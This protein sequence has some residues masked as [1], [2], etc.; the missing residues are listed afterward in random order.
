[1]SM[2]SA[3]SMHARE[4]PATE[5]DIV[6]RLGGGL[7]AGLVRR[8]RGGDGLDGSRRPDRAA[9]ERVDFGA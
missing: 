9:E 2:I 5:L 4:R 8:G 1:V 7:L 3:L 6:D